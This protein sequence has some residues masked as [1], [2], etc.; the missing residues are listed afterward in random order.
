MAMKEF[1]D[2]QFI[3]NQAELLLARQPLEIRTLYETLVATDKLLSVELLAGL[4]PEWDTLQPVTVEDQTAA[5][6]KP[7]VSLSKTADHCFILPDAPSAGGKTLVTRM[8]VE[9]CGDCAQLL[10]TV[11]TRPIRG[12]EQASATTVVLNENP[13]IT[14]LFSGQYYHVNHEEFSQL[15]KLHFFAEQRPMWQEATAGRKGWLYGIPHFSLERALTGQQPFSFL[16]VDEAGQKKA[17]A[18]LRQLDSPPVIQTWFIL[19]TE[20]TFAQLAERIIALRKSEAPARIVDAVRDLH[21][22][23]ERGDLV[24]PNPLDESGLPRQAVGHAHAIMKLLHPEI[25]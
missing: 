4:A 24:I 3:R 19:P 17:I 20:I 9:A 2:Y 21:K 12:E 8:V 10:P 1:V 7:G 14:A 25:N 22:G 15:A 5:F 18:W 16:V 6:A 11:T 13:S 23:A